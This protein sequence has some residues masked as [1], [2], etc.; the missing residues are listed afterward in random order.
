MFWYI[1]CSN[2]NLILIII[3]GYYSELNWHNIKK[4]K[5][6]EPWLCRQQNEHQ[7]FYFSLYLFLRHGQRPGRWHA[8]HNCD[9]GAVLPAGHHLHHHHPLHAQVGH[10]LSPK[11][12]DVVDELWIY[13]FKISLACWSSGSRSTSRQEVTRTPSDC[14]TGDRMIQVRCDAMLVSFLLHFNFIMTGV[15]N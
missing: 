2:V 9:G 10:I 6:K 8:N 7:I 1:H 5:K 14:P 11:I 15:F 13:V 3:Q 4:K 12:Q